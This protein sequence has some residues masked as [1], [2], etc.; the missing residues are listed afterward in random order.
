MG[1]LG[2]GDRAIAFRRSD[3][4]GGVGLNYSLEAIL[5]RSGAE[6]LLPALRTVLD[7]QSRER[8][9][10]LAWSP[11]HEEEAETLI[12]TTELRAGGIR[13]LRPEE[14]EQ[15]DQICFGLWVTLE[16]EMQEHTQTEI[17]E[18]PVSL[19][20]M[21]TSIDAGRRY[22]RVQMTAATSGISRILIESQAVRDLWAE[23]A[24]RAGA[25]VAY[26]DVE[27]EAL[28]IQLY[29]VTGEV[30]TPDEDTL[31]FVNHVDSATDLI[32]EYIVRTNK[33]EPGGQ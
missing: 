12:G 1:D 13:G 4:L 7:A 3:T 15:V 8:L 2:S 27:G 9:A 26:L 31:R 28:P 25:I 11:E 30:M 14:Y 17:E 21:W 23:F 16:P 19:G 22:L 32:C 10:G 29:P 5:L 20:C 6:K 33:L 24:V 18:G